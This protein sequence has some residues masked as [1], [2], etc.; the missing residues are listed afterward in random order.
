MH[1]LGTFHLR[2]ASHTQF[3]SKLR[4][5]SCF[6]YSILKFWKC[7]L[8]NFLVLVVPAW[9]PQTKLPI[10][11][12]GCLTATW[13]S[14]SPLTRWW[15]PTSGSTA[16]ARTCAPRRGLWIP[17]PKAPKVYML[18]FFLYIY[19]YVLKFM[20]AINFG[21]SQWEITDLSHN[22]IRSPNV[23]CKFFV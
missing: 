17:F 12:R 5:S 14:S 8:T 2:L 15:P 6:S 23:V 7:R 1:L 13:P 10:P 9:R 4:P 20:P 19:L 16:L 18:H 11:T 22:R 3:Y 21:P